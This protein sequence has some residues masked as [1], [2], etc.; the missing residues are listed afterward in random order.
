MKPEDLSKY[1]I[2]LVGFDKKTVILKGIIILAVQTGNELVVVDF[3][4]VDAY[5]PYIVPNAASKPSWSRPHF[6]AISS[7]SVKVFR[8]SGR[9]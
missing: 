2:P 6:I 5:S 9:N 1:D 4:I 3:I 7:W 8:R